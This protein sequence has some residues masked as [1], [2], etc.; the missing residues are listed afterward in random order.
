[1]QKLILGAKKL[2]IELT[3]EQI[4]RFET[5]YRELVDWNQRINLTAITDYDEVQIKHFLD[6]L[7]VTLALKQPFTNLSLID[8]GTG[9][10]LPGL[11]LKIVFP[12]I[13]LTLL[14]ATA[15]KAAFLE[16]LKTKLQLDDI[17]I[18]IGR[19][20]ELAH[21][22]NYREKFDIVLSRA[23]AFLPALVELTLPFCTIGGSFIAQKKEELD[24]VQQSARGIT[25]LGGNF[26]E[27][28]KID[29]PELP[30][31]WLVI[32]EKVS[33]TPPQYPRRPGIPAKRPLL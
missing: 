13:K 31:R 33:P 7:T 23:V 27:V 18:V 14:D 20:E 11:P 6:S 28:I 9:A 5:Y 29:L 30:E 21:D 22:S 32:I 24:E 12:Q 16:H 15:K 3:P 10:G 2:G 1:M 4:E 17:E 26:R 25:L 8:V 19:A